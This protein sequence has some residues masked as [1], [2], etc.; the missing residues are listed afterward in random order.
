MTRACAGWEPLLLDRAAGALEA[1]DERRLEAHLDACAA[2]RE[3]ARALAEA[4]A[5]AALSPPSDSER[6]ALEA[7]AGAVIASWRR[8]RRRWRAFS[9]AAAAVAVAAGAVLVAAAPGLLQRGPRVDPAAAWQLPDLE[10]AW[11][12]SALADPAGNGDA[13]DAPLPY[14]DASH[15]LLAEIDEID[16]DQP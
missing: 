13:D 3:E 16:L 8:S 7:S 6:R 12:A 4:L 14:D 15:H 11:E 9:A 2:C 5:L 1:G 10:E